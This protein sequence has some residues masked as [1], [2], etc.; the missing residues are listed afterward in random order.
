MWYFVL[1]REF[2]LREKG[3]DGFQGLEC[4][5]RAVVFLNMQCSTAFVIHTPTVAALLKK[6]YPSFT[7]STNDGRSLTTCLAILSTRELLKTNERPESFIPVLFL[8]ASFSK[9]NDGNKNTNYF[10]V[11][12]MVPGGALLKY[13]FQKVFANPLREVLCCLSCVNKADVS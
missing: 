1:L 5:S 12:I 3:T 11:K 6:Q 8:F 13:H 7:I 4:Q 9:D 10:N 2:N